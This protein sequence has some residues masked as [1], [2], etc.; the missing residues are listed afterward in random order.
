MP[1]Y[2][3]IYAYG[4]VKTNKGH[5]AIWGTAS[6]TR[7][8]QPTKGQTKYVSKAIIAR[9]KA[10]ANPT[11]THSQRKA[12]YKASNAMARKGGYKYKGVRT[13]QYGRAAVYKPVRHNRRVRR[14]YRGQF[15]GSY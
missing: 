6:S 13:T 11:L 3:N 4:A 2:A 14:N 12:A 5:A 10:S 1:K 8:M 9:S 7:R 15:A